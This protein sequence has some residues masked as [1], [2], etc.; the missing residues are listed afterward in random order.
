MEHVDTL[1]HIIMVAIK[2]GLPYTD[3]RNMILRI[4]RWPKRSTISTETLPPKKAPLRVPF[5]LAA[6]SLTQCT[7]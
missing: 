4:R 2:A 3:L 6:F 5:A 7:G 1:I